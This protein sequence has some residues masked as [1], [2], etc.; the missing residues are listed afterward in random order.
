MDSGPLVSV[1]VPVYNVEPYLRKSL[2]SILAQTYGCLEIILVN[3]GSSD[4]SGALCEDYARKDAR[5][6]VIHQKNGGVS[7]ARNTGLSAASGEYIAWV[8]PDDWCSPDFIQYL[9]ENLMSEKADLATCG[10]RSIRG[11]SFKRIAASRRMVLTEDQILHRYWNTNEI[12][13]TLWNKLYKRSLFD[14]ISFPPLVRFEDSAVMFRIL[15]ASEKTV[16]LPDV[17]Y[18]YRLRS[19]GLSQQKSTAAAADSLDV[20]LQVFDAAVAEYPWLKN[21]VSAKTMSFIHGSLMMLPCA[22]YPSSETRCALSRIASR[23]LDRQRGILEY[24]APGWV[25]RL[26][27]RM[28]CSAQPAA[29]WLSRLFQLAYFLHSEVKLLFGSQ[30]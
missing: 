8:D 5:I 6:R 26:E 29:I 2:D 13:D 15:A 23:A 14:R 24:A 9:L 16:V 19:G 20:V 11:V 7:S 4:G 27:L 28:A 21:A 30:K 1:I 17:K 3:D 18:F 22:L 25:G 12:G 10:Y